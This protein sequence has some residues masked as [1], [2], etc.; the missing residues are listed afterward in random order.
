MKNVKPYMKREEWEFLKSHLNKNQRML[1]YGSGNSTICIAPLVKTLWSVEHNKE[2][3]DR[4]INMVFDFNNVNLFYVPQDLPRSNPTKLE[5]FQTYVDWIKD[6]DIKFDIVLI[7][8]RARQ[9]CAES[10]LD[11]LSDNHT[12]FLHDYNLIERPYYKR[13]EKFY[14]IVNSCHTMI[15]MVKK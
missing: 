14:K 6:K 12:V 8:G 15:S 13:V 4:V 9:W 2:W 3:F 10:I 7:D 1:E 5:E 11:K